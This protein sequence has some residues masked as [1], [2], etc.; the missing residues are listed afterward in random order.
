MVSSTETTAS[1]SMA[2]VTPLSCLPPRDPAVELMDMLPP[3]TTENLLATAGN[4]WHRLGLQTTDPAV[5]ANSSW[6]QSDET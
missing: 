5:Y 3:P 6:S 1:T 2:G 4:C